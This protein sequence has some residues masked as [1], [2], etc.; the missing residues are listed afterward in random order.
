M[1]L[2][3]KQMAQN[4]QER[5]EAQAKFD[6]A[7][8]QLALEHAQNESSKQLLKLMEAQLSEKRQELASQRTQMAS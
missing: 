6:Q 1:Q 8:A 4:D 7:R 3:Q 2:V 5:Q